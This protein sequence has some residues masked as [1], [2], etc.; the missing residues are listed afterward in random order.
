MIYWRIQT[1]RNHHADLLSAYEMMESAQELHATQFHPDKSSLKQMYGRICLCGYQNFVFHTTFNPIL[2][3]L[4]FR[5]EIA[6]PIY[7]L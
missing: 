1:I 2:Y 3:F 4:K 5:K 6:A 7:K